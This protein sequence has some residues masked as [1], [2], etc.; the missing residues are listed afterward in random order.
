MMIALKNNFVTRR[1]RENKLKGSGGTI[2]KKLSLL[3]VGTLSLSAAHIT[4]AQQ[5]GKVYRIGY[6]QAASRE[7]QLH[8]VKAFNEGMQ[9]LGYVEGRNITFEYRFAEGK[10]GRLTDLAAELI[11]LKVDLIVSGGTLATRAAQKATSTIPI[12]MGNSGDDPVAEGFVASLARPG[13]NI[14]GLTSIATELSGKRLELIKETVPKV[15]R[16]AVLL[17]PGNPRS[18]PSLKQIEAA[19]RVLGITLQ[20]VAVR[21]PNDFESAFE[22]AAKG[23]ADALI[24]IQDA[25]FNS[26]RKMIVDL[27]AKNRLPAIYDR[28]EFVQAGGVMS[29]GTNISDLYRRAA[30]YVDKILKGAKPADLPVEQPVKFDLVINLKAAEQIRLTIPRSVLYQAD[31]VIK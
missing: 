31:K 3:M 10:S 18:G 2:V 30:I 13:G 6:L 22:A 15:S 8:L 26:H 17:N 16:V 1:F 21:S 5:P 9:E 12:V 7:Q 23:R 24:E 4:D 25:L 28:I 19:S 20:S 27:A 14:T 11:R 29:Y